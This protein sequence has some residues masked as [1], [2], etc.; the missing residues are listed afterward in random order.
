MNSPIFPPDIIEVELIIY[1]IKGLRQCS[2]I[3]VSTVR[4]RNDLI[5]TTMHSVPRQQHKFVVPED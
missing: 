1:E 3:Y 5:L 2:L 4:N